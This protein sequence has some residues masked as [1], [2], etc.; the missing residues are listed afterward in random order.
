MGGG[1][2][3]GR[4]INVVIYDMKLVNWFIL[5]EMCYLMKFLYNLKLKI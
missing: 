3:E 5:K 1:G 4:K 2:E